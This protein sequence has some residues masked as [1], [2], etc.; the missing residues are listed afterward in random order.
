M[1]MTWKNQGE[2]WRQL[3]STARD[4]VKEWVDSGGAKDDADSC[5]V[6]MSDLIHQWTDNTVIYTATCLDI[7]R[8]AN[9][10]SEAFEQLGPAVLDGH[11]TFSGVMGGL[12]YYAYQA[13]LVEAIE[14]IT[15][16]ERRELLGWHQSAP[17]DCGTDE[18][19]FT[20]ESEGFTQGSDEGCLKCGGTI[21]NGGA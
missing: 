15:P 8:F 11:D 6:S 20:K 21:A 18:H 13:D 3:Q 7:L 9:N 19:W 12:A 5:E 1:T 14:R 16:D 4:I 17:C 2:Y 10:E